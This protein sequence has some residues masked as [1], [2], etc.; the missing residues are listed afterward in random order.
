MA[1]STK[2][3]TSKPKIAKT[4][5]VQK[6]ADNAT[7]TPVNDTPH[8]EKEDESNAPQVGKSKEAED[9]CE[10]GETE[11]KLHRQGLS[12]TL[13]LQNPGFSADSDAYRKASEMVRG[14]VIVLCIPGRECTTQFGLELSRVHLS[15]LGMGAKVIIQNQYS[16]MVNFARCKCLGANVLA[17]PDQIPWGRSV[18]GEDGQPTNLNYDYMLWI[19]SDIVFNFKQVLQ[20][21]LLDKDIA[22]GWYLTEDRRTTSIAHW[23]EGEEF[24]KSGVMNHE[25][26]DTMVD[27]ENKDGPK[28][29]RTK[30]FTCD[31]VGFG[32]V[33]IKQGV[34]EHPKMKYPWFRPR[35]QSF[36]DGKIEDMCGEDVGFCLDAIKAG[37]EIWCDPR[38]KVGHFKTQVI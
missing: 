21:I 5:S 22:A 15:L 12:V 14:K 28:L 23:S 17:G 33:M 37:F 8:L 25:R 10:Y 7:S 31:Y 13:N 32:W 9:Y 24:A 27:F 26:L 30:P 29:K 19:D 34:F 35:L 3:F 11:V 20:L 4:N 38:I 1:K 16:S 2:G 36:N 6:E 18:Q